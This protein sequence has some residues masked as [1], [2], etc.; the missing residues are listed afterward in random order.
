MENLDIF[1]AGFF[2]FRRFC[3]KKVIWCKK[4]NSSVLHRYY[5]CLSKIEFFKM[6]NNRICYEREILKS[7]K[8][9]RNRIHEIHGR[10]KNTKAVGFD[11][12]SPKV[13]LHLVHN[14]K[15]KKEYEFKLMQIEKENN[16]LT[17]KVRKINELKLQQSS[18]ES[19]RFLPGIRLGAG[20]TPIVDCYLTKDTPTRGSAVVK[21]S[22]NVHARQREHEKIA[23]ENANLYMRLQKQNGCYDRQKWEKVGHFVYIAY[24]MEKN[25]IGTKRSGS[26]YE[27]YGAKNDRWTF[28]A[29]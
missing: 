1:F 22:L 29:K 3:Q 28:A 17:E 2:F 5:F 23:A 7:Q 8:R 25:E 9:H 21:G 15:K 20:Q 12:S 11:N 24:I 16:H 27:A 6:Y 14:N 4:S 19:M 18:S 13:H 26:E 10:K